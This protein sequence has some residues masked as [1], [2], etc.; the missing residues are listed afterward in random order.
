MI[1][2]YLCYIFYFATEPIFLI[3]NNAEKLRI[4][5]EE[6]FNANTVYIQRIKDR[7]LEA[8]KDVDER[9]LEKIDQCV[10]L[11][12]DVKLMIADDTEGLPITKGNNVSLCVTFENVEDTKRIYDKFVELGSEILLPF[13]RNFTRKVTDMLKMNSELLII[14]LPKEKIKKESGT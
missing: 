8:R 5:L 9:D 4:R 1:Y 12:G 11:F 6:L 14:S 13:A 2:Q 7:P 10:I 3:T